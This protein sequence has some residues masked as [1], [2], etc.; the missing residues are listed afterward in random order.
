MQRFQVR[1]N[2][3][4][5]EIAVPFTLAAPSLPLALIVADINTGAGTAEIWHEDQRLARIR[6]RRAPCQTFWE[7][8]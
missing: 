2:P 5:D 3:Q 8:R 1:I 4:G 7:L 6:K